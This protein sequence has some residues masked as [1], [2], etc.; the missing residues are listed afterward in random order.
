MSGPLEGVRVIDLTRVLAG[1]FAT[2]ILGDLGAE[3]IKVEPLGT[4][5]PTREIAPY[6]NG[7]SH[8][9]LSINR[10]KESIAIDLRSKDGQDIVRRLVEKADVLIENFRPGVLS[11]IGLDPVELRLELPE[12]IICSISGFGQTGPFRDNPSFDLVTQALSGAMSITGEPGGPPVRMGLPLGDQIGGLYGSIATLAALYE[13][14]ST[15]KG[16]HIDLALFDGLVSLL[17][18]VAARYFAT[19]EVMGPV[20]SGHHSSVP[21]RAYE[22]KD[23]W[24]VIACMTDRFWPRICSVIGRPDMA[25]DSRFGSFD[26]RT[27]ARE[28]IDSAVE[29]AV[30]TKTV[31]DWCEALSAADVPHAPILNISDVV[32]HPQ[33][34]HRGLIHDLTHD[35]YGEFRAVGDPIHFVGRDKRPVDPP[36]LLGENTD[37]ILKELGFDEFTISSLRSNR[38]VE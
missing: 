24:I 8:Y 21:Y 36:P 37:K 6:I 32:D 23:G 38:I 1:P 18:Y 28:E 29:D 25:D 11:S 27:A 34:R 15:G 3:V 30:R 10:N 35:S 2:T 33:I 31:E 5:D 9:H 26:Q 16:A 4:G 13:R 12:L 17:G 14:R 19:G 20:G 7:Q 22:A